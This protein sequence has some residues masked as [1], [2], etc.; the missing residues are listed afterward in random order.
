[1]AISEAGLARRTWGSLGWGLAIGGAVGGTGYMVELM[2]GTRPALGTWSGWGNVMA[3]GLAVIGTG[4]CVAVV[5]VGLTMS[6]VELARAAGRVPGRAKSWARV[7]AERLAGSPPDEAGASAPPLRTDAPPQDDTEFWSPTPIMAWRA[8]AWT[9]WSLRGYWVPWLTSHLSAQ[10]Q[11]CDEIPGA[12][13]PCGIYAVKDP[14]Q[15]APAFLSRQGRPDVVVGEV[16]LFGLV[17]E[18]E[19][20]YRAER[21]QILRLIA[22]PELVDPVMARYPDVPV[23]ASTVPPD[24]ID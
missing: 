24:A 21:A 15:L 17:V 4:L 18:H 8:W 14:A 2:S 5:V 3:A 12:D 9:G 22:P 23:E 1:M 6:L 20:G 11:A 10:C 13:H 19:L 7:R 16:A